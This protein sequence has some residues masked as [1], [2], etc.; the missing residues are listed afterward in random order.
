M[1][2]LAPWSLV[3]WLNHQEWCPLFPHSYLQACPK[4]S[5]ILT[6]IQICC[7]LFQGPGSYHRGAWLPIWPLHNPQPRGWVTLSLLQGCGGCSAAAQV[8][9]HTDT[10]THT[11]TSSISSHQHTYYIQLHTVIQKKGHTNQP[12]FLSLNHTHTHTHKHHRCW[13]LS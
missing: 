6:V 2:H 4:E 1:P 10:Q 12:N 7:G 5:G 11:Y 9:T 3:D 8:G 13:C